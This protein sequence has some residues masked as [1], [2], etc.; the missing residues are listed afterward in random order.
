MTCS[1]VQP[2]HHCI[3]RPRAS[4]ARAALHELHRVLKP[5]GRLVIA[6]AF[7]DPDYVPLSKLCADAGSAGFTF[8]K[9]VGPRFAYF[10]RFGGSNRAT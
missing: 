9:K 8:E 1:A 10:A 5:T 6:E 2:N 4:A 7:L 3:C